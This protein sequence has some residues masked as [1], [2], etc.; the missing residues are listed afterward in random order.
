LG[1]NIDNFQ[2]K[3]KKLPSIKEAEKIF[4][5]ALAASCK[6]GLDETEAYRLKVLAELAQVYK[7]SAMEYVVGYFAGK[8][9]GG[10]VL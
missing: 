2:V 5:E 9:V 3:S 6:S 8:K 7:E 10:W 1:L 4:A